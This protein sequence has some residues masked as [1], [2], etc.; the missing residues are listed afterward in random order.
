MLSNKH[1]YH[2]THCTTLPFNVSDHAPICLEISARAI[3]IPCP[4]FELNAKANW[5]QYENILKTKIVPFNINLQE[6]PA[7]G[8]YINYFTESVHLAKQESIPKSKFRYS[9]YYKTSNKFKRLERNLNGIYRIIELNVNNPIHLRNLNHNKSKIIEALKNEANRIHDNNWQNFIEKLDRDKKLNPKQFWTS[10][11]PILYKSGSKR[12]QITDT[13]DKDGNILNDPRQIEEKLR[14]EWRTHFI[15]PP[16]DK[17]H[18]D[19][20]DQNNRFHLA[21]PHIATPHGRIDISRLNS[22]SPLLKPINPIDTYLTFRSFRNKAPGPDEIRKVHIMHFPKI[23]FVNITKIYN[24]ALSTGKYPDN[25]KLGIMIFIPKPGK[26]S[27]D[28]KNYRPITLI[29]IIGKCFGKLLN[30]RFV[31]YLENNALANPLQYGFRKGRSCVSSLA[32]MYEYIV[33]K[34]SGQ[35]HYKVSVVSRDISGAFDR[36]WHKKLIELLSYL[37]LPHL[38]IKILSSFLMN[39]S[40]RIKVFNFIGPPFTP[41]AGVPQGAPDSPDLFN[42]STLPLFNLTP[43][44]DLTPTANT[45]APWYC[46]DLHLIV[47]TPCGRRRH[48]FHKSHLRRAIINQNDFER[49][50]GILT[51]PEKSV[52]TPI[53]R[54]TFDPLVVNDGN[55]IVQYPHLAHNTTT[56]IL[57]LRINN[58]SFTTQHVNKAAENARAIL[59][60]LKGLRHLNISS[61]TLLVKAYIIPALTYPCI[62]L[63]TASISGLYQLQTVLNKSLRFIYNVFFP[64]M[65]SNRVLHQRLKIKPINQTIHNQAKI[66]WEKLG[67]GRAGDINTFN[68]INNMEITHYYNHFPSSLLISLKEEPPPIY[69]R[70]DKKSRRVLRFYNRRL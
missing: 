49:R 11:R 3:K 42:I 34:K 56:K 31:N 21:N 12:I 33:R 54:R 17:I 26:D 27:S 52:I 7:N 66:I 15:E 47:A 67:D 32:L 37:G 60:Q 5:N 36:V 30:K 57:G 50:R 23:A 1:C 55:T 6:T 61:K 2:Y 64:N 58:Y 8:N 46:D 10:I 69:N 44:N 24:Y 43:H 68:E 4:E 65:I 14:T 41:T 29:N 22:D 48:E 28:P 39:R 9:S 59:G 40:I 25:F 20:L 13:G 63:N 35:Q 62:P 45:Y 38:F 51:C 16:V 18:P 19:S 70:R 53:K